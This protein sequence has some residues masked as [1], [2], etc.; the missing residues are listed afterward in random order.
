M[1][2]AMLP[3]QSRKSRAF[4]GALENCIQKQTL[5]GVCAGSRCSTAYL[6]VSDALVSR[7]AMV[8]IIRRNSL[9]NEGGTFRLSFRSG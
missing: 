6:S 8:V 1:A 2:E 5:T 4:N 7:Q 9:V 3:K